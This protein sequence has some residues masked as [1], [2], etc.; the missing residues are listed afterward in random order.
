MSVAEIVAADN[1]DP[2]RRFIDFANNRAV[3]EGAFDYELEYTVRLRFDG[4][5]DTGLSFVKCSLIPKLTRGGSTTTI[6][7][8]TGNIT[9]TLFFVRNGNNGDDNTKPEIVLNTRV[10]WQAQALDE[11]GFDLDF[12]EFPSG[13]SASDLRQ[14]GRL[15]SVQVTGGIE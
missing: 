7:H 3:L 14:I 9:D 2:N 8:A 11:I 15:Y 10:R 4:T 6:H 1:E 12:S 5:E 13:Y